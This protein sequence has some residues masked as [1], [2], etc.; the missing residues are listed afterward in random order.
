MEIEQAAEERRHARPPLRGEGNTKFLHATGDILTLPTAHTAPAHTHSGATLATH[1]HM[2]KGTAPATRTCAHCGAAPA[3]RTHEH[4]NALPACQAQPKRTGMLSL[5][6]S[7]R[8]RMKFESLSRRLA[9]SQSG[10]SCL[11]MHTASM[12]IC[13]RRRKHTRA[14]K[15]RSQTRKWAAFAWPCEPYVQACMCRGGRHLHPYDS[16]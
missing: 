16:K 2:S 6:N 9:V 4:Q 11:R 10:R 1:T 12:V 5:S 8:L 14:K 13:T 7:S 15:G 3:T